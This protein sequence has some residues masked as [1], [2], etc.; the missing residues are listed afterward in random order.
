MPT[1]ALRR[2]TT[3][4]IAA[5]AAWL[6]GCDQLGIESATAT[7]AKREAEGKAVGAG[8]R[9]AGRSIEACYETNR[10]ADKAA[11]FAGWR[12]MED[13]MRDNKI[14]AVPPP[15]PPADATVAAHGD[16]DKAEPAADKAAG[17][18]AKAKKGS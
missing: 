12:E 16:E 3:A 8:C 11:V 14:A 13:Y 9:H 7:A 1:L 5:G 10:R 18:P 15:P 6:A 4:L 2:C 17:K